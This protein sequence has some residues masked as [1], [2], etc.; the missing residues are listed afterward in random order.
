MPSV[1]MNDDTPT[2]VV[3]TPLISPISAHAASAIRTASRIGTPSSASQATMNAASANVCPTE[4]SISPE[5]IRKT[6]P[7]AMI[8]VAAMNVPSVCRLAVDAKST[9]VYRK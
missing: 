3:M 2:T 1:V 9:T 4:R 6:W 8:A 5:I 7:A